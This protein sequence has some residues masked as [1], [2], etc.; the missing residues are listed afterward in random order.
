MTKFI[1]SFRQKI[2]TNT[3]RL[4]SNA[5]VR[6]RFGLPFI[7]SEITFNDIFDSQSIDT[8]IA[9]LSDIKKELESAILAVDSL[10]S[11]AQQNKKEVNKLQERIRELKEDKSTAENLL[12]VPQESFIPLMERASS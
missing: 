5:K 3:K 4:F 10:Q 12:K 7:D 8:R 11:E 9:P 1:K 2:G 6:I